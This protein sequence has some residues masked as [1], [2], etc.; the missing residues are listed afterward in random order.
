[1]KQAVLFIIIGV[2]AVSCATYYRKNYEFNRN[3]EA[4]NLAEAEKVLEKVKKP[5]KSKARLL[6]FLNKGVVAALLGKHE[7]SNFAFERAHTIAD[8]YSNN[9][10]NKAV[11]LLSNPNF[12]EY[13]GED[14]ELLLLHYYKALN[15]LEMGNKE[16]ALVECRRMNIRL[17]QLSDK[18][19]GEEKYRRDAFAHTLMGLIY[20]SDKDYNNAFIAYRNALNIY[21]EDYSKLFKMEPPAQLKKDLL[22]TAFLNRFHDDLKRYEELFGMKYNH[23]PNEGAELV[24]FWNNGLGPVKDEWGVNFSIL[25]GTAGMV[26]FHNQEMGLNFSFPLNQSGQ[27]QNNSLSDLEFLRVAFPKYVERPLLYRGAHLTLDGKKFELEKAQD[28]NA[29]AHKVLQQRMLYEF[30]E[31]LLR[32]ALKK[33]AEYQLRKKNDGLGAALGAFNAVTEKADTRNWQTIP[34]SIHY[35]RVPLKVGLQH[36]GLK[37]QE[38]GRSSNL[39]EQNITVDARKGETIFKAFYSLESGGPYR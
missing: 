8:D 10:L 19:K 25:R 18:Y 38:T 31:S 9:Y 17:N 28:V 26:T 33:A 12:T 3:F 6:Y 16:A 24:F 39:R 7:E 32:V 30:G 2:F 14:H 36:L 13:P 15:F 22:R 20:D 37:M 34:H 23:E 29:V 27:N 1:M 35:T 4:G 5:E 11:S 21:Q